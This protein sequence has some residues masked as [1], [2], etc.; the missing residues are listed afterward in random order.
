MITLIIL[1]WFLAKKLKGCEWF[2]TVDCCWPPGCRRWEYEWKFTREELDTPNISISASPETRSHEVLLVS[3]D[4]SD[5]SGDW[6]QI[7]CQR[8][9]ILKYFKSKRQGINFSQ[10]RVVTHDT[11]VT[12]QSWEQACPRAA[13]GCTWTDF[14]WLC[15][16]ILHSF[17]SHGLPSEWDAHWKLLVFKCGSQ[18]WGRAPFGECEIIAVGV[19]QVVL[20]NY[21]FEGSILMNY[22]V[23]NKV[24]WIFEDVNVGEVQQKS[25]TKGRCCR[26]GFGNLICL[27]YYN[28]KLNSITHSGTLHWY[29]V[30]MLRLRSRKCKWGRKIK[31]GCF[32]KCEKSKKYK[33]WKERVEICIKMWII[34]NINKS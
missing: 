12:Q 27:T 11:A 7:R 33:H 4:I 34:N 20:I 10:S 17:I 16:D 32:L 1:I 30:K 13:A 29:G 14:M 3:L 25:V 22:S 15:S 28:I 19:Q 23:W 21:I 18:G 5:S 8:Y 31:R 2:H 6:V 9:D 24:E 26:E